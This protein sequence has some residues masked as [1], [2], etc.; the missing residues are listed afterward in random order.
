[1]GKVYV[2]G[3]S[4]N[5]CAACVANSVKEAKALL[6]NDSDVRDACDGEYFNLRVRRA[7]QYDS[8]ARE[9][10]E[11]IGIIRRLGTLRAMGFWSEGD[12]A[13]ISCDLYTMDGEFPLCPNCEQ[14][15]ECGHAEDCEERP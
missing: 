14:C 4:E 12:P 1:M 8:V 5:T 6:W 9:Y 15:E 2:G 10:Q 11:P 13:C 3:D 7:L